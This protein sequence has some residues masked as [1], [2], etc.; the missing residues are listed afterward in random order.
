MAKYS[1][2]LKSTKVRIAFAYRYGRWRIL[3]LVLGIAS[4]ALGIGG[5]TSYYNVKHSGVPPS[6]EIA[7]QSPDKPSEESVPSGYSVPADQPKEI[8]LPSINTKG[9]IQ[10]V[11]VDNNNQIVA[12]GNIHMAGWY[13]GSSKPGASGLS[14]ID[15]HVQGVYDKGIFHDLIRLKVDDT[16]TISYGDGST[17]QFQV[18]KVQAVPLGQ[19]TTAL[20]ERDT[21]IKNQLNVITCGG[22]YVASTNTYD[23][24]VIVTAEGM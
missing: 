10:R 12:P 7:T 6:S 4:L 13:V 23:G 1:L 18:V 22:K 5:I 16:F 8:S 17:K 9:F 19:A 21:S 15:G 24:R 14:I 20:F 3:F 2:N 11:S